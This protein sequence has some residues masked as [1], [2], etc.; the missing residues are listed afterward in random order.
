M[1]H[2][3]SLTGAMA[4]AAAAIFGLCAAAAQTSEPEEGQPSPARLQ[5]MLEERAKSRPRL[6]RP[7]LGNVPLRDAVA[8]ISWDEV[9]V[10]LS[11]ADET[12]T[13]QGLRRPTPNDLP[14]VRPPEL[15]RV[16]LPILVPGTSEI[17]S[18]VVVYG[19][20][21][22]YTAKAEAGD[23]AALRVSGSRKRLVLPTRTQA[24][25]RLRKLRASRPP[26]PGLDAEYV[27]TRSVSSTDLSFSRFGAGY[28]L[29]LMCDEPETDERCTDDAFITSLASSMAVLNEA[30]A[31]DEEGDN[32]E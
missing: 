31:T 20:P 17:L 11:R 27:I 4:G 13:R 2:P 10:L 30:P 5:E 23:G 6:S 9:S 22:A 14:L 32:N 8:E 12:R 19:Q 29:S 3:Q 16:S 7:P 25:E 21:D 18:S 15:A 24:G 28:V 1:L 26:L